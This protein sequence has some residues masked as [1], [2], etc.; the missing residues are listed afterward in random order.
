MVVCNKACE[1]N[2]GSFR[3]TNVQTGQQV[4]VG[5]D[6]YGI[7]CCAEV[8]A[9]EKMHKWLD[10][11][12]GTD[13]G[14]DHVP[15]AIEPQHGLIIGSTDSYNMAVH[16]QGIGLLHSGDEEFLCYLAARTPGAVDASIDWSSGGE[17]DR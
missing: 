5:G 3:V 9:H 6:G 10:E 8:I 1:H 4:E 11:H 7:Y 17:N 15:D 2:D 14:N 13:V 16:V 12:E